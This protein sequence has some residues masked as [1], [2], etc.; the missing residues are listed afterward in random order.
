MIFVQ[1][2]FPPLASFYL[3]LVHCWTPPLSLLQARFHNNEEMTMVELEKYREKKFIL[4]FL[5]IPSWWSKFNKTTSTSTQMR[6]QLSQNQE[7]SGN[8]TVERARARA[9]KR[10]S[11]S[12]KQTPISGNKFHLAREIFIVVV[13]RS[14]LSALPLPLCC[15]VD[16]VVVGCCCCSCALEAIWRRP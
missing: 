7:E 3:S 1:P 8:N 12:C 16:V 13:A 10:K 2:V 14:L 11:Q 5:F 15:V 6:L 4:S 9:S